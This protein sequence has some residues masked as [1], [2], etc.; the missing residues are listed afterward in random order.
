[1]LLAVGCGGAQP[2][3]EAPT[4]DP[5][6]RAR[7]L[8]DELRGPEGAGEASFELEMPRLGSDLPGVIVVPPAEG[9]AEDPSE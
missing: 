8:E 1:M 6:P 5:A 4:N 3:A 9:E 7:L 2:P